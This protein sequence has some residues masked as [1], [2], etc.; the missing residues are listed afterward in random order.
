MIITEYSPPS[1]ELIELSSQLQALP[2]PLYS[3]GEIVIIPNNNGDPIFAVISLICGIKEIASNE[4]VYGVAC[5]NNRG[6][7][8]RPESLLVKREI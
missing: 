4:I 5:E 7:T 2:K 1:T 6:I 8:Y 3:I